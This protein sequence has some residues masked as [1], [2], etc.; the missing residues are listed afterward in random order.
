MK[1]GKILVVDD[2]KNICQIIR[3]YLEFED[4]NV[5]V[6]HDGK[7]ALAKIEKENFDLIILDI[8]LP[9]LDGLELCQELRP[10]DN[11]PIIMLSAKNKE[12]DRITGLELGA[13]DY[14]TKPFS[15]K[16]ITAR[17]KAVLR[18]TNQ[19]KKEED[20]DLIEFPELKI[21]KNYRTVKVKGKKVKLT[22]KEFDLLFALSSAPRQVF[23]REDLL[24]KVWGYDYFGD[25]RT[26]DTHIKSLRKKLDGKAN[27]YIKTVW[28]VG[29]K[30]EVKSD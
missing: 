21:N 22:P 8:M 12:I 27:N 11:T 16:E 15:P 2:D 9:K 23:A 17:V 3:E 4:F 28:G 24:K 7:E 1:L 19:D 25:I 26:V 29:Y 30:F 18:R 13:D 20:K 14:V 6:V 10:Q 5:S